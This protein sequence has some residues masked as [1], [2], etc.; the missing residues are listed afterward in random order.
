MY[1]LQRIK[2]TRE[3]MDIKQGEIAAQLNIKQTQ[4]SR[5]ERG[6]NEIPLRYLVQIADILQV[7]LDYLT[8]RTDRKEVYR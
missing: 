5:Y 4:Y 1:Y 3:D 2:D 8:E 7:S 6:V